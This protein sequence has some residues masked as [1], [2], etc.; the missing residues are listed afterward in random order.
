MAPVPPELREKIKALAETLTDVAISY[1]YTKARM[2]LDPEF[3]QKVKETNRKANQKRYTA[4]S[5][6]QEEKVQ[7]LREYKAAANKKL[8]E[9]YQNDEAYR[10]EF[11]AKMRERY[12]KSKAEKTNMVASKLVV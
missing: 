1:R 2:M 9:K 3:A 8:K 7:Q 4:E 11:L 12:H 10:K 6:D 5:E